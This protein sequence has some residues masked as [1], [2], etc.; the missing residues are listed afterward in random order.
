MFQARG[1]D[2]CLAQTLQITRWFNTFIFLLDFGFRR[3][4]SISTNCTVIEYARDYL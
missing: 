2:T 3:T 1:N 4:L